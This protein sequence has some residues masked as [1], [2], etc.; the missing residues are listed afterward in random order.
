MSAKEPRSR[1]IR[2]I[3]IILMILLMLIIIG[4]FPKIQRYTAKTTVQI[5]VYF[6][7]GNNLSFKEIEYIPQFG[8]YFVNYENRAH[9]KLSFIVFPK[10]FP[11]FVKYD[12]IK[13]EAHAQKNTILNCPFDIKFLDRPVQTPILLRRFS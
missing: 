3:M 10:F 2:T 13:K 9:E 12:P 7:Y 11:L 5:Y 8:D 1:R 4:Q 6:N